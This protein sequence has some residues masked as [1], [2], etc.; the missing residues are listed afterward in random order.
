MSDDKKKIIRRTEEIAEAMGDMTKAMEK[1]RSDRTEVQSKI[2]EFKKKFPDAVYLEPAA[3]IP[4][5]G[6]RHPEWEKQREYLHE[7]VVGVFESQLVGTQLDFFLTGLPGDDYCRWKIPVNKPVGIPRFVA[8]H[9]NKNL[10][11]KE[12]KPLRGSQE[13]QAFESEDMM[14]PFSNFETKRRGTFHPLNAY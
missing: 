4:T 1:A 14:A 8:Q 7:Y 2:S 11:W 10:C 5:S 6:N 3:R 9:L 13:P 12:M